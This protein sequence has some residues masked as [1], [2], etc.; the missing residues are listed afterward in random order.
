MDMQASVRRRQDRPDIGFCLAFG[1]GDEKMRLWDLC[2]PW[3][4]GQFEQARYW[5]MIDMDEDKSLSIGLRGLDA[6]MVVRDDQLDAP[7][8][9]PCARRTPAT[10]DNPEAKEDGD[11]D[12]AAA[13]AV[14]S[15]QTAINA[16]TLTEDHR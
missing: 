13:A 8:A 5:G 1:I 7:E 15:D 9:A 11:R 3:R 16:P 2:G 4:Q 12:D 6:R 10:H 14:P